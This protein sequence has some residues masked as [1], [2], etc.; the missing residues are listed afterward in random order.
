MYSLTTKIIRKVQADGNRVFIANEGKGDYGI[1]TNQAGTLVISF[2]PAPF[3]GMNF[4]TSHKALDNCNIGQGV[5]IAEDK[6]DVDKINTTEYL[7]RNT[8][9]PN[10]R[11]PKTLKEH[12]EFYK[13]SHYKEIL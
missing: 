6:Y 2:W 5:M 7:N 8:M 9:V 4:A 10:D 1:F 13:S 3:G 12:L 11:R